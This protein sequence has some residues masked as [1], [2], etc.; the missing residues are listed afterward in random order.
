MQRAWSVSVVLQFLAVE[1][2]TVAVSAVRIYLAFHIVGLSV[3]AGQAVALTAAQ[4]I[5]AAI[6]F[7]PA[8]LGL[9]ELIA[10]GIA[11]AVGVAVSAAVASTVVDRLFGQIGLS[12]MAMALVV[13]RARSSK[14]DR[15]EGREAGA[16]LTPLPNADEHDGRRG[17]EDPG[18]RA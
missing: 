17:L 18:A 2:A 7:F 9:R 16:G 4:I 12:V 15:S 3:S 10:G 8:G 13:P 11:S 14:Y 6:G 1:S 5:A